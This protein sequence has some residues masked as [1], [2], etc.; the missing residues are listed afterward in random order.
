MLPPPSGWRWR[1]HGI[2]IQH[3][4]ALQPRRPRLPYTFLN[5]QNEKNISNLVD[6]NNICIYYLVVQ[7]VW[8][9]SYRL[10]NRGYDFRWEPRLFANAS[11]PVLGP[12]QPPIQREPGAL[13]P[14]VKRPGCEADN[15][16]PYNTKVEN[17]WSYISTSPYVFMSWLLIKHRIHLHCTLL[18]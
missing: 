14:R 5:I 18:I 16:P 15:S 17:T 13:T 9:L 2:L 10:D 11:R 1:Q 8:W 12:T 6:F 3:Y 7:S 4:T